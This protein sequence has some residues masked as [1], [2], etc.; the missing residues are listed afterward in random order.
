MGTVKSYVPSKGQGFIRPIDA[1]DGDRDIQ[2]FVAGHARVWT[3]TG[4]TGYFASTPC[5]SNPAIGDEV[6]F[7]TH[8]DTRR[9]YR[10]AHWMFQRDFT[11]FAYLVNNLKT[12]KSGC[13]G[14][15]SFVAFNIGGTDSR[16]GPTTTYAL[17][18]TEDPESFWEAGLMV[19]KY[20][21]YLVY[22]EPKGR[23][24]PVD[25]VALEMK[26]GKLRVLSPA[27][28]PTPKWPKYHEVFGLIPH[29]HPGFWY[30]DGNGRMNGWQQV[31]L[32]EATFTTFVKPGF[33]EKRELNER[34]F[35]L[36]TESGQIVPYVDMQRPGWGSHHIF[37]N[38][39]D[40][41]SIEEAHA[42]FVNHIECGVM[43]GEAGLPKVNVVL[44]SDMGTEQ[45]PK[46][47]FRKRADAELLDL[48][49]HE[50]LVEGDR[51][52]FPK[53]GA[54]VHA[55]LYHTPGFHNEV[56]TAWYNYQKRCSE[57]SRSLLVI[58]GK[59]RQYWLSNT[60]D[61]MDVH[62]DGYG[63]PELAQ[64]MRRLK[65]ENVIV[66][67]SLGPEKKHT[68]REH[69][70]PQR[71]WVKR[72]YFKDDKKSKKIAY[73]L[74]CE[75]S[76]APHD[77]VLV[78][79]T[80]AGLWELINH[81]WKGDCVHCGHAD[82]YHI[83]VEYRDVYKIVGSDFWYENREWYYLK[84]LQEMIVHQIETLKH[85]ITDVYPY[86]GD[87]LRFMPKGSA[88]ADKQGLYLMCDGKFEFIPGP[89]KVVACEPHRDSE[90]NE[91][92]YRS[93][94][95]LEGRDLGAFR[96]HTLDLPLFEVHAYVP[97]RDEEVLASGMLSG[98]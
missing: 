47:D 14:T 83:D 75:H 43:N 10:A 48:L 18:Q 17:C 57:T 86:V 24:F 41:C 51:V 63:Y 76:S 82:P 4:V 22:Q 11:K 58:V 98:M 32:V 19:R 73:D 96:Q 40:G 85:H 61:W 77:T 64:L 7:V 33:Y 39:S 90:S 36:R 42:P 72:N 70:T 52:F 74:V 97:W 30:Y 49:R 2:F 56:P 21:R 80:V 26:D 5:T 79:D 78:S 28:F 65:S 84:S 94:I 88:P 31:E 13:W 37:A 25:A 87:T 29:H 95:T 50:Y 53:L 45:T 20:D 67:K 16:S 46:G 59:T 62:L 1:K 8:S 34:T 44:M 81:E 89:I 69:N 93:V 92:C 27:N 38:A 15:P 3:R 54:E 60:L 55:Y 68:E 6:V 91:T 12:R 9:Q 23:T 71:Y 66:L 35:V